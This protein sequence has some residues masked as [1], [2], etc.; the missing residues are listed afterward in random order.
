[1]QVFGVAIGVAYGLGI[2]MNQY[3]PLIDD[4]MLATSYLTVGI[5]GAMSYASSQLDRATFNYL[6]DDMPLQERT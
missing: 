6:Q 2:R 3:N 1:M 5:G 4:A